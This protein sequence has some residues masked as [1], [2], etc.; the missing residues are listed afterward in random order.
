MQFK[1]YRIVHWKEQERNI[2]EPRLN[3]LNLGLLIA[4]GTQNVPKN[5]LDFLFHTS[6]MYQI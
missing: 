4:W 2:V 6:V 5:Q 1:M 3:T